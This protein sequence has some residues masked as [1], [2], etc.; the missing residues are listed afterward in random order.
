[1]KNFN[2]YRQNLI[3]NIIDKL[4]KKEH[5]IEFIS[6]TMEIFQLSTLHV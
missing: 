3:G 2:I 1:M 4:S 6:N 5:T